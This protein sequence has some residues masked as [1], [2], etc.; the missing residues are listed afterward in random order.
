MALSR[1]AKWA[2]GILGALVVVIGGTWAYLAAFVYDVITFK[3]LGP[4]M[5]PGFGRGAV[6][7]VD[8]RRTPERGDVVVVLSKKIGQYALRRVVGLPGDTYAFVDTRP[9]VNGVKPTW[10]DLGYSMVDGREMRVKRE[11]AFG[12]TYL[13]YDDVN[14]IM[15]DMPERHLTGYWVLDDNRDY[16]LAKDS[17]SLDDIPRDEIRGVVTWT[18]EPGDLPYQR[19]QPAADAGPPPPSAAAAP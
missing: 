1:R 8:R 18:I 5:E 4:E 14:R 12:R 11:H 19:L 2:L 15:H 7:L 17:R 16:L 9:V 6:L 10:D 3:N 13:V